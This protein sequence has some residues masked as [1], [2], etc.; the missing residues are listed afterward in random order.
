M[1]LNAMGLS[2]D[3]FYCPRCFTKRS[4]INLPISVKTVFY[5]IALFEGGS[6]DYLVECQACKKA[7]APQV[8]EP[9]NQNLIKLAGAA[10]VEILLGV[11]VEEMKSKLI[12]QGQPGDYADKLLSLAKI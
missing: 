5:Y 11:S 7:F 6:L 9:Y 12:S 1:K 8:L 2:R 4:Y 10:R 3:K